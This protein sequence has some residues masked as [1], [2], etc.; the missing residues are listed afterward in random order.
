MKKRFN[1][2]KYYKEN[3]YDKRFYPLINEYFTRLAR[4]LDLSNDDIEY[5]L[6]L[7]LENVEYINYE[8]LDTSDIPVLFDTTSRKI[9]VNERYFI[10]D[11]K[12]DEFFYNFVHALT[13]ATRKDDANKILGMYNVTKKDFYLDMCFDEL[14]TEMTANI[15]TD[16]LDYS[17]IDE[18]CLR[19]GYQ[20]LIFAGDALTNALGLSKVEFLKIADYCRNEFD[21]Y[22]RNNL[23]E[24]NIY[25]KLINK[26]E[27]NITAIYNLY[28]ELTDNNEFNK[29]EVLTNIENCFFNLSEVLKDIFI[30]RSKFEIANKQ[31]DDLYEY[32]EKLKYDYSMLNS[33]LLKGL[34]YYKIKVKLHEKE[35]IKDIDLSYRILYL[36]ALTRYEQS[37]NVFKKNI[38]NY[39]KPNYTG[40]QIAEY[41]ENSFGMSV[42]K[43]FL[44]SNINLEN[45]YI[46]Y[47]ENMDVNNRVEFKDPQMEK[48]IYSHFYNEKFKNKIKEFDVNDILS[49]IKSR[50][51]EKE[52]N[53][54]LPQANSDN[55][56]INDEDYFENNDNN[57]FESNVNSL[58]NNYD[59]DYENYD[60]NNINSSID[61]KENIDEDNVDYEP[62]IDDIVNNILYAA[63]SG[64]ENEGNVVKKE[65]S[66]QNFKIV[67]EKTSFDNEDSLQENYIAADTIEKE[68]DKVIFDLNNINSSNDKVIEN[69]NLEINKEYN[70]NTFDN[71]ID[72]NTIFNTS[73]SLTNDI[74]NNTDIN[75]EEKT[76]IEEK[77]FERT[78]ERRRVRRGAMH[79]L[80]E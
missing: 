19:A 25:G 78:N 55:V 68:E 13:H 24:R 7:L 10:A 59:D 12:K 8:M 49:K 37:N 50:F 17:S 14:I 21:I 2:N 31:I 29:A 1:F 5:K 39:L 36:E 42:D 4:V 67:D 48:Y 60:Y 61:K 76:N 26:Y 56:Y 27:A 44:I 28:N 77:T 34:N 38:T 23:I 54:Y 75:F 40:Y 65:Q 18:S 62:N 72:S 64:I 16:N 74:T 20:S 51:F 53:K 32:A 3:E 30:Q 22:M 80:D 66:T 35:N 15:L 6:N 33:S 71:R 57:I 46:S 70:T 45:E 41:I 9:T 11:D 58:N 47:L 43:D 69:I 52:E 73:D 79:I 63:Q